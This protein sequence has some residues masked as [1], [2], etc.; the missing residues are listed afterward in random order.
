M[1]FLRATTL[2][3]GVNALPPAD[4]FAFLHPS[5][6][7]RSSLACTP[8]RVM[9]GSCLNMASGG[10]VAA[11]G[12]KKAPSVQDPSRIRNVALIGHSH[13]GKT[14]LAEWMLFDEH[15]LTKRPSSGSSALDFDPVESSRH[16]SVFS[17][18]ARVPHRGHLLELSDTPWGDFPSD[19]NAALDGADSAVLVV[20][21]ADGVQSGTVS[22]Y[23]HCAGAGIKTLAALS[24]MDRPFA[25]VDEVLLDIEA[26]L[27]VKPVPIQGSMGQGEDF[28]GVI[29]L[30][31]LGE[32]G[33]LIRNEEPADGLEDAW[34][35]LE[36][37]VAMTDDD[38][39]VEYLEYSKLEPDQVFAGL[40]SAVRRGKILPL[41]YTS[42]EQDL[43]VG[44]LMDAIVA[45][46]PNPVEMREEA[47]SAA[48]EADEARCGLEPGVE[49]GFAARVLHTTVDSFGSLSV[50]RVISNGFDGDGYQSFPG[51]VVNLRTGD[52]VKMPSSTA[53][54]GL[55]GKERLPLSSDGE[56]VVPGD[57]IAVPKLPDTVRTNDILTIPAA[58]RDEEAEISVESATDV[59]TPLSR[60]AEEVPLMASATVSLA[61][62][63]GGK[64]GKGGKGGAGDDKLMT[65]LSAIAREDLAVHVEH[66][67]AS[68]KLLLR[69][70]S[71]DHLLLLAARL[72]ERY[73]IDVELG[74]PPVQYRE[75]LLKP[76]KGAEG[77]HK[78]Q[79]GGSGQFGVCYIDMEPLEEGEGIDFV[80]KI[81]GGVI[82]KP[83]ISSVE[84]GVRE[85]LAAGGPLAGYPV[86]DV[87][88]TLVD[89]K[90]HSVD[91]KDIAFQSAG[92]LAVKAALE[93][94]KTK[95]LQPMETVTFV[96]DES[97]QGEVNAIV[98]RQEGYVTSTNPSSDGNHLEVEAI[99]PTA[100]IADV[101]DVLR[102][103][104]AGEGQF[105]SEFSHYQTVPEASVDDVV[106][107]S[108]NKKAMP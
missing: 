25:D 34:T 48:C 37:A 84:K 78:K 42:A 44:E 49:S 101:S 52:K 20:S 92:K 53:S 65:A 55:C 107:N 26:S 90:M 38:L 106:A 40:R 4:G 16:S 11:E 21:A 30:F 32:D 62:S 2:L 76:I 22:A 28:E 15:I 41:V 103:K 8:P 63:E 95:L 98:A 36:E 31:T 93:M 68:G 64:K 43:G 89:G 85:Q 94:G 61:D 19:A 14:A 10:A 9:S 71:G 39:L 17:H 18:F 33:N 91:S 57:I 75:T 46:L 82:S 58:M 83:F 100:A 47:L 74:R 54:F 99:L 108:P 97:L 79:S 29:P 23:Q 72:K 60:H 7:G 96:V 13:S 56:H 102:A 45:V 12:S 104:S 86:T 6:V 3:L 69:C 73:D 1:R 66:D 67:S 50:L 80:S 87:R 5:A 105:T 35:E 24:K 81:K 88:I 51:E 77:R 59:L 70:M 27:G